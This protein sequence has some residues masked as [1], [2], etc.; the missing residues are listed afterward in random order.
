MLL[1]KNLPFVNVIASGVATVSL[2]L[3]MSYNRII[4]ALGG[5]SFTKAMITDIKVKLNGKV[6]F[7]DTG[8]RLNSVNN[9]RNVP[10]TANAA[11]LTIDFTEPRAKRMQD[12]LI[13]NINT[14]KGATSLTIEVTI[15][16]ATAPT[17]DSYSE[18]SPPDV[19]GAIT[20]HILFTATFGSSGKFPMKLIDVGNRG[21]LIKRVHFF[22]GGNMT[23]LEV[24]KNG[25]VIF[26]NIPTAVNSFNQLEY[27]NAAQSNVYTYDPVLDQNMQN[28]VVTADASSLEFN[29]TFSAS[30]S[31]TA[32][33]EAIDQ[34]G[35]L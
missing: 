16:G 7:Q 34:L 1:V 20:K 24:K 33:L 26:D 23:Q 19:L 29:P 5:T 10:A 6:I 21:A 32:V 8:T 9:Y 12:Q 14:A 30:D 11:Y 27:G 2:P 15:A 35:N 31:V 13:G 18:L 4:L 17:L 28:M 22:H 3:G 25:I